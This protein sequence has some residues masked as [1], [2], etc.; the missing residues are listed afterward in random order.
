MAVN[1]RIREL[2]R[3]GL[4]GGQIKVKM[5]QQ[6]RDNYR[7]QLQEVNAN[8]Q[9]WA[10]GN[11][12]EAGN[13]APITNYFAQVNAA[14]QV[15]VADGDTISTI[16]GANGTTPDALLGANPDVKSLKTG[17]VIRTPSPVNMWQGVTPG[18]NGMIGGPAPTPGSEAWRAQNAGGIGVPSSG[19]LGA[20]AVSPQ[21]GGFGGTGRPQAAAPTT[22]FGSQSPFQPFPPLANNTPRPQSSQFSQPWNPNAYATPLERLVNP[23]AQVPGMAPQPTQQ[24]SSPS[25]PRQFAPREN[26]VT[27]LD[28]ITAATGQ[29]GRLPTAFELELLQEHGRA[30]P[31]RPPVYGGG[32]Y[33]SNS[34][35]RGGGGGGGGRGPARQQ[36]GGYTYDPRERQPAFGTGTGFKG[37]INWRI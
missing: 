31:T 29:T 4:S 32:G 1:E 9:A 12:D 10:A 6:D 28:S 35:R 21:R 11:T 17:M 3:Q 14:K 20:T 26:L 2:K 23:Q 24:P 5:R 15:T 8:Y 37:L 33:S 16:A 36:N 30:N 18:A 13:V 22:G 25:R 19:P 27:L 34:R 7:Q